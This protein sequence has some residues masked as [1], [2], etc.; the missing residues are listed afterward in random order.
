MKIFF[1]FDKNNKSILLKQLVG[2]KI[3][4]YLSSLIFIFNGCLFFPTFDPPQKG[5]DVFNNTD[6]ILYVAYS[7]SDSLGNGNP[8]VYYE[9]VSINNKIHKR[10]PC[11]RLNAFSDGGIGIPGRETLLQKCDKNM[12]RLFFILESTM[13]DY[14][15]EEICE[16]KIYE[17]KLTLT[18]ADLKKNNWVVVY[19]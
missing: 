9:E 4:F 16:K 7:F 5:I 14:S 10:F 19:E 1:F 8:I 13:R 15:W 12:L 18:K 6:S 2:L 11:Y 3:F 17:K